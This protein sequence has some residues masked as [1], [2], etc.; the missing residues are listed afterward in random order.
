VLNY[1]DF[2]S[3][4]SAVHRA[5]AGEAIYTQAQLSGPYHLQE[6]AAGNGFIYPPTAVPLLLPA[7]LGNLAGLVVL[8]LGLA[9]LA[10]IVQ[11]IV[12]S[13]LQRAWLGHAVAALLLLSPAAG[14]AIYVAQVTPYIAAGYGATWLLPRAAGW[15]GVVGGLT[16]VFPA[17]LLFWWYRE[18][19]MHFAPLILAAAVVVATTLWLGLG[20]WGD[21]IKAWSNALPQC[22]SPSLGSM[23]CMYGNSGRLVGVG[24]AAVLLIGSLAV[25][26]RSVAF[27][28]IALGSIVAAPDVFP[29]YLLIAFVG[30]LPGACRAAQLMYRAASRPAGRTSDA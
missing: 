28:G 29:N 21:Y 26:W 9:L 30:V 8:V 18:R 11:L 13:A 3:Y 17:A 24:L 10:L 20:T 14:D 23:W 5:L 16:K 7:G 2:E 4:T 15:V 1:D 19:Q 27:A 6:L 22:T 12:R 25:P